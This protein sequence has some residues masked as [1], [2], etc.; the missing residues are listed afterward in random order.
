MP[1]WLKA[2]LIVLVVIVVLVVG[3]SFTSTISTTIFMRAC[4]DSSRPTPGFCDD[5]P[6]QTE[7]IKSAQWRI[8][9]C[10]RVDLASDNNCQ[11]LFQPV[12][13]FCDERGR[14]SNDGSNT[15]SY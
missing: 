12:Q 4:L 10:R 9:Q 13:Q 5:V 7:F 2:L 3:V 6:K 11:N 15:N 1:G 8:S 14:K